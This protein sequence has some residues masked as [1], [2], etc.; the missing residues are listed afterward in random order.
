MDG[1]PFDNLLKEAVKGIKTLRTPVKRLHKDMEVHHNCDELDL[2][3]HAP[4]QLKTNM[5]LR[6]WLAWLEGAADA[7]EVTVAELLDQNGLQLEDD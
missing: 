1:D 3:R 5:S 2:D 6:Y 7:Y 4:E